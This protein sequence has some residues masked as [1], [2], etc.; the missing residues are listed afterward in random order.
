MKNKCLL[1]PVCQRQALSQTTREQLGLAPLKIR[2]SH[3]LA[4]HQNAVVA[5]AV[6]PDGARLATSDDGTKLCIHD[7]RHGGCVQQFD[8]NVR[9]IQFMDNETLVTA[10][11]DQVML[12][13]LRRGQAKVVQI[14]E[15]YIVYHKEYFTPLFGEAL[16]ACRR[17]IPCGCPFYS[18]HRVVFLTTIC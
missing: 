11:T 16:M 17:A 15:F 4:W 7:L 10:S 12:W 13:A 8:A 9:F 5:M 14:Y 3:L 2:K 6:S 18:V 1:A